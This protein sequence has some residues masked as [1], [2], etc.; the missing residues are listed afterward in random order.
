[1]GFN[2]AFKGLKQVLETVS[3]NSETWL[4]LDEKIIKNCDKVLVEK[5]LILHDDFFK[6][7]ICMCVDY[8]VTIVI[9]SINMTI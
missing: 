4:I 2:S 6:F 1:M 3:F 5:L 8:L 9:L 7:V